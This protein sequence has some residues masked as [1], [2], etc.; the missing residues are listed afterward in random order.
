MSAQPSPLAALRTLRPLERYLLGAAGS[1]RAAGLVLVAEGIA[2]AIA[3]VTADGSPSRGALVMT[4]V[5]VLLRVLAAWATPAIAAR[6]AAAAKQRLRAELLPAL[7]RRPATRLGSRSMLATD[8][9]DDLDDYAA[10]YLPALLASVTVPPLVGLVILASDPLSALILVC[11]VPL[12]PIFAALIGLHTRDRVATA[13]DALDRLADHLLELA[14]GLPVLVGLSRLEQQT[15]ALDHIAEDQRRKTSAVL[16]TAFLSALALEL[17]ATLSVAVIAVVIGLRLLSGDLTLAVG[18]AVLLLAPEVFGPLRDVGAA[19]H[20]SEAGLE[21]QRRA[22][23]LIDTSPRP[24]LRHGKRARVRTTRLSVTHAGRAVAAVRELNL[25]VAPGSIVLLAGPSGSGKSSVIDVL[26]GR[27]AALDP[28]ASV[29]GQIEVEADDVAYLPQHPRWSATTLR[30]ELEG[31]GA[32]PTTA[33]QVLSTL[34]LA[35]LADA[36]P[37]SC[38]PGEVRRLALARVLVRVQAGARTVLLDEPTAHLDPA[39]AEQVRTLLVDLARTRG[40]AVILVSHDPLTGALADRSVDLAATH[41]TGEKPEHGPKGAAATAREH[42]AVPVATGSAWRALLVIVRSAAGQF[43]AATLLGA[44]ATASSVALLGVSAWLI[45]RAA[46]E[47]GITALSIAIVGVRG[48]GIGRAVLR[49]AERLTAHDAALLAVSR[50][51]NRLWLATARQGPIGRAATAPTVAIQILVLDPDRA[52]DGVIRTAV[53]ALTAAAAL[54][55]GVVAVTALLPAAGFVGALL[56]VAGGL[57]AVWGF[58]RAG[59]IERTAATARS[60]AVAA[61]AGLLAAADDLAANGAARR[62]VATALSSAAA[63]DSASA[64]LRR[65]GGVLNAIAVLITGTAAIGLLLSAVAA[66]TVPPAGVAVLALLPLGLTGPLQQLASAASSWPL[67]ARTLARVD[68][69]SAVPAWAPDSGP[70]GQLDPVEE[71]RLERL[72]ATYPGGEPVL[73]DVSASVRRGE[74]LVVTGPSGSGKSTL[75]A[76]LLRYLDP[77]A[78]AVLLN[79]ID[80]RRIAP[81]AI[82][83]RVAWCPQEAHLFDSTIRGNL[84]LGIPP[85]EHVEETA[86]I[87][88]LERAGLADLLD[89]LPAGLD[90]PVGPGGSWLSGGQRQRLAVARTIL[91]GADTILLDEPTAHLDRLGAEA[92]VHDLTAALHEQ[93]LITVTHDFSLLPHG[94]ARLRLPGTFERALRSAGPRLALRDDLDRARGHPLQ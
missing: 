42:R 58:I 88:V 19:F 33:M 62:A 2:S 68:A 1:V 93:I 11:T 31:F 14:R 74:H 84:L 83:R 45:V 61:T 22:Q 15:A 25:D 23:H 50:L 18:L 4:G 35:A 26:A 34:G 48:L 38:S 73:Q 12:V 32:D 6:A 72:S 56:L 77:S 69:A 17:V 40:C 51:R 90:T 49:Y 57:L 46:E 76:L 78:G 21:S 27:G 70:V 20:Q 67:L 55:G 5:G 39:S 71:V 80:E 86:L 43:A 81:H 16:R 47:P 36:D 52:R 7:V 30:G 10:E 79:G 94:T 9:L 60:A 59:T 24:D 41:C 29:L 28:Q 54:L 89:T 91:T 92:L 82:R 53:P 66:G 87:G 64:R 65:L 3:G 85:G 8:G 13:M 37:A 44:A 75:L 63:A